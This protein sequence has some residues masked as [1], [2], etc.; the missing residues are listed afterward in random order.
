MADRL[1]I[2]WQILVTAL[3]KESII[4][5]ICF[6]GEEKRLCLISQVILYTF[7]MLEVNPNK[8]QLQLFQRRYNLKITNPSEAPII[9]KVG[10]TTNR[11][12]PLILQHFLSNPMQDSSAQRLNYQFC[13]Q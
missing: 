2:N 7:F 11:F 3:S 1:E 4:V 13:L 5:S 10:S 8:V 9:F 12:V 6:Y